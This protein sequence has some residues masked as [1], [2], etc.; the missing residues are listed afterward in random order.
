MVI[1]KN[2]C[3]D[4]LNIFVRKFIVF[5]EYLGTINRNGE[6]AD[7]IAGKSGRFYSDCL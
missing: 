2:F 7:F 1:D 4:E 6:T 3:F 5:A